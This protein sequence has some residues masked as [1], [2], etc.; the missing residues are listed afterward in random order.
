MTVG[1]D[2]DARGVA[3][4]LIA[5][6]RSN[7]YV[8]LAVQLAPGMFWLIAF[9]VIPIL[10]V[11]LYSFYRFSNGTMI[12]TLT[13]EN[14]LRVF[15]DTI[16]LKVF[17]KS[18]RYGLIVTLACLFIGY[19]VAYF[20]ARSTYK[21]RDPLFLALIIPFWTSIV[22]RTY[23]WKMLLGTNGLFNYYL[24]KFGLID[25]PIRLLYTEQAVLVGLVHVFLP[26]MILPLYAALEKIDPSLEEAAMDLG[27][28]RFRTF[29]KII[30]PLSVPGVSTGCLLV[31]IL[32]IGSFL[33]PDLLGGSSQSMISNII[34]GE[35]YITF[36][37]PFGS[38]LAVLLLVIIL[39]M[40]AVY[41]R[42]FK[43]EKIMGE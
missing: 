18:L 13:L 10:L 21:R 11:F 30:L 43:V 5:S 22:V 12:E 31:F 39:T 23:A 4:R 1:A 32:A 19:P 27:A 29:L 38:A 34:R 28:N 3:S 7:L 16:Y 6:I 8:K 15:H 33:T 26:F 20:L 2:S 17:I 9:F 37:W 40:V 14:Y 36:N 41:N 25:A 42:L 35:F 24:G